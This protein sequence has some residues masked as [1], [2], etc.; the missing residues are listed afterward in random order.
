MVPIYCTSLIINVCHNC[1]WNNI[2]KVLKICIAICL[3]VA[4][5]AAWQNYLTQFQVAV[6]WQDEFILRLHFTCPGVLI[7]A[8]KRNPALPITWNVSTEG[9]WCHL[10][11][12]MAEPLLQAK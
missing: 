5:P 12:R 6:H 9:V 8:G 7:T 10:D 1:V 11:G 4:V 3:L 2:H